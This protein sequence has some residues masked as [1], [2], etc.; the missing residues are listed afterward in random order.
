MTNAERMP[1]DLHD[2]T[3]ARLLRQLTVE[4][5]RFAEMFGEAHG[6]HRTDLNALV[7]IMAATRRGR[8]ISPGQL[9]RAL[10]LSASATTTVLDRLEIA[11]YVERDRSSDDRRRVEL[12]MS[13]RI[14]RMGEQYF[15]PL[16]VEVSRAWARFT[17]QE[18]V[19]II[20]FL[21]AS[22][23]ATLQVRARLTGNEG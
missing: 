13:D 15:R 14:V 21:T 5:D 18:R 10:H 7:V 1:D 19:T 3:L 2:A 8:Q 16:G 4:T 12:R 23:D 22:I 20:E 11:G 6:L 9:A 17:P